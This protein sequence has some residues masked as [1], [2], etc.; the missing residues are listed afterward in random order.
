MKK[1][2]KIFFITL[3]SIIVVSLIAVSIALWVVFTPEKITPIAQKQADKL[4]SC[5]TEI[6][7]VEL[8]FFS[9][10]PRFGLKINKLTI[11]NPIEGANNDTLIGIEKLVAIV[12][13]MAWWKND[14]YVLT[15]LG[16]T[17]GTINIFIDSLGVSNYDIFNLGETDEQTAV[18]PSESAPFVLSIQQVQLNNISLSYTDLSSQMLVAANG[19]QATVDGEL[20]GMVFDGNIDIKKGR[21][22]FEYAGDQY[23]D[24]FPAKLA[25]DT[26]LDIERNRYTFRSI[27]GYLNEVELV[28]KG[29]VE[30]QG[31]TKN[32]LIDLAY[33][34]NP[35]A[36]AKV[37]D[38]VPTSVRYYYD[39]FVMEG[40]ISSDG[41]VTGT[42]NENE[43][44]L[45]DIN[46]KLVNGVIAYGEY[47][48]ALNDVI[49]EISF[50]SDLITDERT[51]LKIERFDAK[52]QKSTISTKGSINELFSD[53][54]CD[55]DTRLDLV[56][57]EFNP[58]LPADMFINL[59]GKAKGNIKSAFTYTQ[60]EKLEIEKMKLSGAL[61]FT[62]LNVLYDTISLSSDRLNVEFSLP[63]PVPLSPETRF[64]YIRMA[65]DNLNASMAENS[66]AYLGSGLFI[67]E[68]SDMRDSTRMPDVLCSFRVDSLYANMDTLSVAV[69]S[70]MGRIKLSPRNDKPLQPSIGIVYSSNLMVANIGC[71]QAMVNRLLLDG[72]V[73]NDNE[74]ED[75][76]LQWMASGNIDIQK[77]DLSL[78]M[79]ND[80]IEIPN[81]KMD[82]DPEYIN[83]EKG[84]LI[85][86]PSDFQLT[87]TLKNLLSYY[88]GDSILRGDLSFVSNNTDITQLM[89][90][91]SGIGY[92]DDNDEKLVEEKIDSTAYSGPYMV[93]KGIDL[94]LN[95]KVAHASF[96]HETAS[97]IRG[98]V[99]VYDGTL[100]LDEVKL[101]TPAARMQLTAMYRTPRKNHLFLGLD[102][103]M[104]DVEIAELL[105]MIP[106]IDSIM[107]MLRSFGGEGEF[108]M[109]VETYLDSMYNVKMS[110]L[111]GA[112]SIAGQDLVL[113][114]GET[115]SEIAKTLR[116][117]KQAQNRV[118][119]IS[120]EFTVF[121]EEIDIYP[122]V[123]VIDKYTAIVSGRHNFDMSFDYHI[124]LVKSPL[125]FNLGVDVRGTLDDLKIRLAACKYAEFYRP[126]A[127]GMVQNRQLELR[128][129]IRESLIQGLTE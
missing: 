107:P 84:T 38:L 69:A 127:R 75:V 59:S 48:I 62:G 53:I 28:L 119:S 76:F 122:F 66:N 49:A 71:D 18:V 87:G 88:R 73:V 121:R 34:I 6:D 108:H 94:I 128:R 13:F 83:I 45:V 113:M 24:D 80:R 125:P 99:R 61:T 23:L 20:N 50:V 63:N 86:G 126:S 8:T 95:A 102:Y 101:I 114:D 27:K 15:E 51:S 100:V 19:L 111:R 92:E 115:F 65:I 129:M 78:S 44:P 91:T 56:L 2:L 93:P 39:G 29:F 32:T 81:I 30:Y 58:L 123:T 97:D 7:E 54:Y 79:L 118:D 104:L 42:F 14:E 82:F 22:T 25:I 16:L 17:N 1:F 41:K 109:A 124:S 68:M 110:T 90:L 120:A 26:E 74:Q 40:V 64:A 103:H 4:I 33:Q 43:M 116:F 60:I 47:P 57:D 36:L 112:A 35:S 77:G 105:R 10:F 9:T 31:Q 85:I 67:A 3:A 52:A 70:P 21:F 117:T 11:I 89:A 96:G 55:L 46:A 98:Q 72:N 5:P 12:D 37:L 106:D